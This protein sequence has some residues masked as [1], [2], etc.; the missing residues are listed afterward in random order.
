METPHLTAAIR[1][2]HRAGTTLTGYGGWPDG[3][4]RAH[5]AVRDLAAGV[6][7]LAERAVVET[8]VAA[9]P[10]S[11]LWSERG[12]YV[13]GGGSDVLWIVD[14]VGDT[15]GCVHGLPSSAVSVAC[16]AGGRLHAGVVHDP[17][18]REFFYAQRGL[19]AW[20]NEVPIAVAR[21]PVLHEAL[22]ACAFSA[23]A[24]PGREREY[25]VF[26][27]L[28]D[29]SRGCLRT[30]SAAMNL[31]HVASGKLAATWGRKLDIWGVAA[32]L[33]L[34]EEA[35]GRV[36]TD[37]P[38]ETARTPTV[39]CLASNGLV[40]PPLAEALAQILFNTRAPWVPVEVR[41]HA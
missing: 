20:R 25:E 40:H 30:G 27:K 22:L 11:S 18:T 7:V 13:A 26:G 37:V 8:L 41:V 24:T 19:G 12:G 15:E 34:V 10:G 33:L 6:D 9:F 28:N 32:G 21:T 2:A 38:I 31:A 36:A 5:T 14:P 29:A 4:E 3:A 35:G 1:A 23:R 16:V 39:S 17:F